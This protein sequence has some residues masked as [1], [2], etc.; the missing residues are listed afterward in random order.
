MGEF[1]LLMLIGAGG[2]GLI[3][4]VVRWLNPPL[5]PEEDE[6]QKWKNL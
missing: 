4:L 3:M 1:A 5:E 2:L 6:W